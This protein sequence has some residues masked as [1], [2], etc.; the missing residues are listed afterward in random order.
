VATIAQ[1]VADVLKDRARA[2]EHPAHGALHGDG[3]GSVQGFLAM[4]AGLLVRLMGARFVVLAALIV[5]AEIGSAAA[6]R[7]VDGSA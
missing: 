4:R 3:A 7:F 5:V 2:Q 6:Q 1:E